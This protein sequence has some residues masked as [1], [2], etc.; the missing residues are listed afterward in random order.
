LLSGLWRLFPR[1]GVLLSPTPPRP[2]IPHPSPPP[3]THTFVQRAMHIQRKLHGPEHED[4]AKLLASRGLL[5]GSMRNVV[6]QEADLMASLAMI[7]RVAR[8]RH[9]ANVDAVFAQVTGNLGLMC[10]RLMG[11]TMGGGGGVM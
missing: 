8:T 11:S 2:L 10:V 1:P 9:N 4:V 5:H 7:D 6:Q 3:H